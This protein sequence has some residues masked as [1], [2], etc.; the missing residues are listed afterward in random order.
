[1][2]RYEHGNETLYFEDG[3][4]PQE[5]E[6]VAMR[7]D[8]QRAAIDRNV[9]A[10]NTIEQIK[11]Y[12]ANAEAQAA[13]DAAMLRDAYHDAAEG[14]RRYAEIA[15]EEEQ[16]RLEEEALRR[17]EAAEQERLHSRSYVEILNDK[18]RT[19]TETFDD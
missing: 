15:R 5:M 19:K 8:Q 14:Q 11:R 2:Q 3:V 16:A 10:L 17:A 13:Q 4:T 9:Q 12:L 7:V 6:A 18:H 1:M